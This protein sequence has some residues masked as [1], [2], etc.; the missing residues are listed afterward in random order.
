MHAHRVSA[1]TWK[2]N[3]AGIQTINAQYASANFAINWRDSQVIKVQQAPAWGRARLE[4]SP[5]AV[6]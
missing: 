1:T 6:E 5:W 3:Q 2:S 4:L